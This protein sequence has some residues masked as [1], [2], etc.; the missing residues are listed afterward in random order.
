MNVPIPRH[1]R[2]AWP[3]RRLLS[4]LLNRSR[5]CVTAAVT[6]VTTATTITTA[7]TTATAAV[8]AAVA[9]ESSPRIP[10]ESPLSGPVWS[11]VVPLALFLVALA[12]T[13]GL[14]RRFSKH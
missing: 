11:F 7:V 12:A 5:A 6:A 10:A 9:Q 2:A 4:A 1:L 8:T 3:A 14:Y 13:I